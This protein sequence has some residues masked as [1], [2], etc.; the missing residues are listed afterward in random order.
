MHRPL[1]IATDLSKLKE[2][3]ELL[4][5]ELEEVIVAIAKI[6]NEEK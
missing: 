1:N 5:K 3:K 4:L 6:E 2:K